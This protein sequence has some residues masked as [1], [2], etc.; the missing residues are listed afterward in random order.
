[1]QATRLVSVIGLAFG[2][3]GKG[4][5]V[6]YLCRRWH[7]HTVVRFN[8]GGQAGHNV[9]L[10]DGRRHTFSQFG[11][12]A[13]VRGTATVLAHPVVIHPGAL[14]LR[15]ALAVA[16][17]FD[18]LLLSHLDVFQR[19]RAL[20]WCSA[21][22]VDGATLDT[23][24]AGAAGDLAHQA[25]LTRLLAGARPRYA[26]RAIGSASDFIDVLETLAQLPVRCGA[27]GPTHED[28]ISLQGLPPR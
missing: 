8:G 18:G 1:M 24:A 27:R 17:P 11:A 9:V 16:G 6:D 23:L 21:Y 14:L 10:P 22:E 20:R 25:G 5:F 3:C 7:A 4:L 19:E 26:A 28:V 12:G 15:Y 2:D 13:F